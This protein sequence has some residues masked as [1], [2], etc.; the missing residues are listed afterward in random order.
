MRFLLV[1]VR[2][3]FF[4]VMAALLLSAVSASAAQITLAWDPNTEPDVTGY[5]VEYGPS[6]APYSLSTNVGN[7]TTWTLT[8][9]N[10][11]VVYS[12]RV[13]AVNANGELSGPSDPVTVTAPGSPSAMPTLAIDRSALAFGIIAGKPQMRT[14]SQSVRLTQTGVGGVSWTAKSSAVWLQVSPTN[15]IGS[16]TLTVTL[17]PSAMPAGASATGA[18]SFTAL[19]AA[20]T[21]PQI[22]VSVKT[23]QAPSST[24][25]SG[26]VDSPADQTTGVTGSL[27]ITGWAVDDV[28]V[29]RVRIMRDAV[30]GEAP[31]LV[32][33]GNAT[34]VEDMRP[35]VVAAF[36]ANPQSYRAGWGYLLLTNMLPFLGNGTF[37]LTMFADDADGHSKQLG[38]RTITCAN[39]SS[40]Q[41]FGA[42]DTPAPGETVAGNIYT[43]YGWVL[44]R[45]PRHADHPDGGSTVAFIDGKPI[46]S[47]NGWVPR[48]D[49]SALFPAAQYPGIKN[50]LA[51][52]AFDTTTLTNGLHTMSWSVTDDNGVSAGIGSRF[53]RVFNGSS[54]SLELSPALTAS[55]MLSLTDEVASARVDA[56]P[57]PARRG[58]SLDAPFRRYHADA[59]GLVTMQA[60]EIDRLELQ[61]H[62]S[63]EGYMMSG[64]DLRPLPIGSHLDPSTGVFVWQPGVGFIGNYDLVFVR[65]NGSRLD[66]QDV[67]IVL[68]PKGSNRV[69]PQLVVD[70]AGPVV[71]GWAADL[72]A[73]DG[74]GI[75]GIHVWAY[76]VTKAGYGEPIFVDAAQYGGERPDVAAVYGDRFLHSGY[77]VVVKNLAPGTYDLALF[78]WSSAAQGFLSAKLVRVVVQ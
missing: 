46:G 69:G 73:P 36:P 63:T 22:A 3:A 29:A 40:T 27:A 9:A 11:G 5:V 39:S 6:Y 78:P 54:T 7:T 1:R 21:P 44:S 53:F 14:S 75:E 76:P 62:G 56:T 24:P 72:D 70:F 18:I 8:S 49:L 26:M 51:V 50:A 43:S 23:I 55:S 71:A 48:N 25:P 77:G 61:T 10:P 52:L 12:F 45:G 66:R 64:H 33:L 17:V 28:D 2:V 13:I 47:P 59:A 74:T 35:D 67:R 4:S 34:F 58:Y 68:N 57:I 15:G 16:A 38:T 37:K 31:G 32:F 60:E 30:P 20:N 42:I 65:R 41:P 19:G